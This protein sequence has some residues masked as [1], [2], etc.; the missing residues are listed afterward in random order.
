[1]TNYTFNPD[2]FAEASALLSNYYGIELLPSISRKDDTIVLETSLDIDGIRKIFEDLPGVSG[3]DPTVLDALILLSSYIK[4]NAPLLDEE[5]FAKATKAY[6]RQD[7][8]RLFIFCEENKC[9]YEGITIRRPENTIDDVVPEVTL[10]IL[11]KTEKTAKISVK[12]DVESAK[13]ALIT[14][15]GKY[16]QAI[17]Q[18][19]ILSQNKQ[20]LID[21]MDYLTDEE[22]KAQ[23]EKL[24]MFLSDSS[25]NTLK[26]NVQ[27]ITQARYPFNENAEITM[28]SQIGIATNASSYSGYTPSKLRGYLE[29]D[30]KKLDAELEKHLEDIKNI[31]GYDTDG[32]LII[33]SGIG[34]KLD[35]QLTAYVQTG[36]IF[37]LKTSGLD[38]KI[39]ASEQKI[40]RLES[41][42]EQKEA[43]LRNKY[44]QME[45]AL[46]SLENQQTT[47]SNFSNRGNKE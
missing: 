5:S 4:S 1:M 37:A 14:F 15:V 41:Q 40:T 39:K 3:N 43:D 45:G 11:D 6:I 33:D 7:V 17:G 31:F 32:D 28:L 25:L 20:E 34:Y 42:M 36:G 10:N 21:E 2:A 27:A 35:K 38:T 30:E 12:P 26:S 22:K 47:I 24:G 8:L 46:N 16:N 19:N 44:G 13:D 18:L 23:R 29:I 9:S